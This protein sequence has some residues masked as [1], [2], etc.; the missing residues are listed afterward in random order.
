[1]DKISELRAEFEKK[2]IWIKSVNCAQ[3]LKK[4]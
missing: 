2:L 3:S 1:M 4:S